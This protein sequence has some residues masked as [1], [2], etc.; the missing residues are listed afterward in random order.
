MGIKA[1]WRTFECTPPFTQTTGWPGADVRALLM[2]IRAIATVAAHRVL[3]RVCTA[4]RIP[5]RHS[6][7]ALLTIVA[8]ALRGVAQRMVCVRDDGKAGGCG[9]VSPIAVWVVGERE[10]VEL[11][12]WKE[13]S[14][15]S[16][17]LSSVWERGNN[18]I[19]SSP[20]RRRWLMP[21]DLISAVVAVTGTLRTS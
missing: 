8:G 20:E 9:R 10:S 4:V 18:G 21:Y 11:P 6:Y 1:R 7:N 2:Q 5:A 15:I 16:L 19:S 17:M 14:S 13:T 3:T 12:V